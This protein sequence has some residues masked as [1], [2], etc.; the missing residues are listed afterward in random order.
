MYSVGW[1]EL[2]LFVITYLATLF[3]NLITGILLGMLATLI[4][5]LIGMGRSTIFFRNLLRPNT[6]LYEE[7]PNKYHLS[8]KSFATFLNFLRIKNHLDTIST[9]AE[10][11]VDFSLTTYVDYSVLEHLHQYKSNFQ[12][13]GGHLEI[14]G[15]DD[16]GRSSSHPMANR[17]PRKFFEKRAYTLTRR[18][19]VLRLFALSHEYKFDYHEIDDSLGFQ[20]F[21]YFKF[22]PVNLLR[23]RLSPKGQ[24]DWLLA[25]VHYQE[26]DFYGNQDLHATMVCITLKKRAPLFVIDRES[27]LDKVAFLA[28]FKDIVFELHPDF[29]KRFKVKG[30]NAMAIKRFLNRAIINFLEENKSYHIECNGQ[31]LLIFE[32]ERNATISEIKQMDLLK[33]VHA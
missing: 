22:K 5:Q 31:A 13:G 6:L 1:E 28:G 15:L 4:L 23:N 8:V 21:E 29:S 25:D 9:Q 20:N 32:K 14:I 2:S 3:T 26:G 7:E 10:V 11:I 17:H 30:D 16:M 27:L 24:L 19:K 12:N 33:K 18:Q